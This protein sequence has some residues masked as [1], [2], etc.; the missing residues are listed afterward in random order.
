[1]GPV[2]TSRATIY[3]EEAP[4]EEERRVRDLERQIAEQR[5]VIRALERS[6]SCAGKI[7]KP[8][9]DRT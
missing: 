7:L 9:L 1:M 2:Y 3:A 6:L 8:Y 4:S 5:Q